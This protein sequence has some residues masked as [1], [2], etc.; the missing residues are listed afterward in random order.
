MPYEMTPGR[1]IFGGIGRG[2]SRAGAGLIGYA[3]NQ[4]DYR[5]RLER[6]KKDE[7]YRQNML[8]LSRDRF[9]LANKQFQQG[10]QESALDRA[11]REKQDA[12]NRAFKRDV[13]E[14]G[15]ERDNIGDLFRSATFTAGREDAGRN[16]NLG[17]RQ[18]NRLERNSSGV[19]ASG[20][21]SG[22]SGAFARAILEGYGQG[23]GDWVSDPETH[24][25]QFRPRSWSSTDVQGAQQLLDQAFNTQGFGRR[26]SA[27]YN[28]GPAISGPEQAGLTPLPYDGSISEDDYQDYLDL[29]HQEHGGR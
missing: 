22:V 12:L 13:F 16:Y 20:Y 5:D 23:I 3:E 8:G 26:S 10:V 29:W 14:Y 28:L 9:G 6:E 7:A 15:K 4:R 19:N 27:S 1:A 17:L 2:M 11:Y 21:P 24:L 25:M 18:E